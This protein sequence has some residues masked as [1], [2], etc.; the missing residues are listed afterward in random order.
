MQ[1]ET[2]SNFHSFSAMSG[3]GEFASFTGNKRMIFL[4]FFTNVFSARHSFGSGCNIL[5]F[6]LWIWNR[7]AHFRLDSGRVW[8]FDWEFSVFV[9]EKTLFYFFIIPIKK[10]HLD[11]PT[12]Y[13]WLQCSAYLNGGISLKNLYCHFW[14][15][16]WR[17]LNKWWLSELRSMCKI[18]Q[19]SRRIFI[20]D[21]LQNRGLRKRK[22]N[23]NKKIIRFIAYI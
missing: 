21:N 20:S 19:V 2:N 7:R 6:D 22:K 18:L 15:D 13:A 16:A 11:I 3:E 12:Q 14:I 23:I 10:P 1:P 17:K 8:A 9:S 5:H 4:T